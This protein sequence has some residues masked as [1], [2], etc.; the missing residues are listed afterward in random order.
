MVRAS[1]TAAAMVGDSAGTGVNSSPVSGGQLT[2]CEALLATTGT[3]RWRNTDRGRERGRREAR[4]MRCQARDKGVSSCFRDRQACG[5]R[6]GEKRGS[7]G[8]GGESRLSEA[9]RQRQP[10]G[11]APQAAGREWAAAV[12]ARRRGQV[13]VPCLSALLISAAV[14]RRR[15]P[16]RSEMGWRTAAASPGTREERVRAAL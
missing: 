15:G 6:G 11:E 14:Q 9:M 12:T 16:W 4:K 13:P 5:L 1:W 8:L 2:L 10:R 3:N 7:R